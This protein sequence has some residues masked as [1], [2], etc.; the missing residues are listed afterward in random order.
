MT[1]IGHWFSEAYRLRLMRSLE[2]RLHDAG[3]S[4]VAGVDE[5]ELKD[6][7]DAHAHAVATAA[8]S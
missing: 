1:T 5:A 8:A 7:L 3:Y 6:A 4:S 2:E